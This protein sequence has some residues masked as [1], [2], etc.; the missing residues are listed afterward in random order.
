[1]THDALVLLPLV[2]L[3]CG[4]ALELVLARVLSNRAKGWLAVAA[5]LVA[6][7]GVFA[8][9]PTTYHGQ[10]VNWRPIAWD[11]PLTLAFHVDGL[12]ELFALMGAGIGLAVLVYSVGYMARDRSATRFYVFM[13]VF[14]AGLI[15]LVYSADLFVMYASWELVGLCS[16][17]LVGFWYTRREAAAGRA[18]CWS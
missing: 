17:F 14:I 12:S 18:R 6:L 10:V 13:L 4:A 15:N 11:G 2:A 7:G 3:L 16:F 5:C 8:L 9:W 1:M